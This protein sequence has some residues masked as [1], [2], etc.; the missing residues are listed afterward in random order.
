M[1]IIKW[2]SEFELGVPEMDEQHETLVGMINALD[3]STHGEYDPERLR[4]MLDEL[5]AY[6]RDHFGFE[7]RLMAGGGCA[8]DLVERHVAEHSHFRNV[9]RDLKADFD[10][11]R[12]RITVPLIEYLV[13][14]L[15]HHIVV[16][17]RAMVA[18]LHEA[19][20]PLA[21]RVS[22]ALTQDV[23]DDLTESERHLLREL[24]RANEELER[25]VEER[26]RVLSEANQVLEAQLRELRAKVATLESRLAGAAASGG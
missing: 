26:T 15:L 23:V 3:A 24:R 6:V 18:Q 16:V 2:T 20:R 8:P 12:G 9:L 1:H 4:R 25:Q 13:H 11:G 5:S 10:H 22:A 17:D 7:E 21:T 19:D 14:W